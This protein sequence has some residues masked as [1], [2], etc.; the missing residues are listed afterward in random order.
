MPT[1]RLD[2]PRGASRRCEVP[3]MTTTRANPFIR[4]SIVVWLA[5]LLVTLGWLPRARADIVP[6][7]EKY[8]SASW[9]LLGMDQHA[10]QLFVAFPFGVCYG[11]SPDFWRLNPH[12]DQ[13][14]QNYEVLKPGQRYAVHK[15]CPEMQIYALDRAAFTTSTE[16]LSED[17]DFYRSRGLERVRIA[18]LDKLRTTEKI[19][20]FAS[21]PRVRRSGLRVSYPLTT[22]SAS[23]VTATHE[24]LRITEASGQSLVVAPEAVVLTLLD[25][26]LLRRPYVNGQRPSLDVSADELD[27]ADPV[28]CDARVTT[29]QPATP[30]QAAG[31]LTVPP[32]QRSVAPWLGAVAVLSAGAVVGFSLTRRGRPSRRA[33]AKRRC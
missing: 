22:F 19:A 10:D 18:E 27:T 29:E 1:H 26:K 9:E 16:T 28:A 4:R 31:K 25:A 21:D 33:R 2:D 17:L 13:A 24:L 6:P 30:E 14:E 11:W 12:L 32:A 7:G 15:F 8:I 3:V 5:T 20:F 23:V